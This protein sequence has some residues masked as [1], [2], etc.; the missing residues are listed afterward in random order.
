MELYG[1]IDLHSTNCHLAMVDGQRNR[2]FYRKFPNRKETV[3][4][5]LS[6]FGTQIRGIAVESTYN[7]YWLVDALM[8]QGYRVH[9]VN[10]TQ[11]IQ[12]SGMKYEDDRHDA[13]WL[14]TLLCLGILPE[15][16]IYPRKERPLR[17][18]FRKRAHLVRVRTALLLSQQNMILRN[19]G[20]KVSAYELKRFSHDGVAS[21][22]QGDPELTLAAEA[23]KAVIDLLTIQIDR[24]EKAIRVQMVPREEFTKVMTL[25]GVGDI[26]AMAILL[27]TGP[28]DRFEQVGDYASYSR[29]VPGV[30]LSNGKIKGRGNTRNGNRYLAWA[31][32]EA[33][34]HARRHHALSRAFY[35]RKLAQSNAAV[36]HHALAHKLARAAYYIMRDN[37]VFDEGKMF[38]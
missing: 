4:N 35:Q 33:A 13:F 16:Y 3:L 9:L 17:D 25:P 28:I 19:R 7:W 24:L 14:A 34:D 37:V 29:K 2:V 32:S 11:V 10:T 26:L 6:P 36:A 38:R 18:L 27:E 30:W 12:Y 20:L 31:F 1:A 8:E 21:L 5:A 15:G 23:N 22:L